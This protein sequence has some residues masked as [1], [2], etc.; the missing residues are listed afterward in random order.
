MLRA[1]SKAG[2]QLLATLADTSAKS[3]TDGTKEKLESLVKV[4]SGCGETF[5]E[6]SMFSGQSSEVSR[7]LSSRFQFSKVRFLTSFF[8]VFSFLAGPQNRIQSP[9]QKRFPNNGLRRMRQM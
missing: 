7:T 6:T 9:F 5:D 2:P 1:L 3:S 8:V 4:A